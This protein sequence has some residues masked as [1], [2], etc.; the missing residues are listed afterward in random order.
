MSEKP[1]IVHWFSIC[2]VNYILLESRIALWLLLLDIFYILVK[3]IVYQIF[4]SEMKIYWN[5]VANWSLP[6]LWWEGLSFD[7]GAGNKPQ[8]IHRKQHR[9]KNAMH[10]D[11]NVQVLFDSWCQLMHKNENKVYYMTEYAFNLIFKLHCIHCS[12]QNTLHFGN[13]IDT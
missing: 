7:Y 8:S 5:K 13:S 10:Q 3:D 9:F 2:L 11:E 6:T 1:I 4:G 12:H